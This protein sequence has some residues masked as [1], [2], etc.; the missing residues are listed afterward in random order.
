MITTET[1]YFLGGYLAVIALTLI[2][3]AIWGINTESEET[4]ILIKMFLIPAVETLIGI[5]MICLKY[6]KHK[7]R[8]RK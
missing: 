6:I 1:W 4:K 2:L 8:K 5:P 7:T 3:C